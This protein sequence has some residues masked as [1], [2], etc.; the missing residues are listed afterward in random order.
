MRSMP[1]S[2][3][4]DTSEMAGPAAGATM[5]GTPRRVPSHAAS[6]KAEAMPSWAEPT[7]TRCGVAVTE[8]NEEASRARQEVSRVHTRSVSPT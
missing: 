1:L 2:S 6:R 5:A 8:S 7:T 4:M 3:S